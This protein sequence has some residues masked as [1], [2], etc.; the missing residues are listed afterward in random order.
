MIVYEKFG[1]K[2]NNNIHILGDSEWEESEQIIEN[3]FEDIMAENLPSLVKI[4][5]TKGQEA[6]RVLNKINTKRS[7]QGLNT[8]RES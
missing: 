7:T 6:Y 2:C 1:I 8:K 3:L 5:V 4:K